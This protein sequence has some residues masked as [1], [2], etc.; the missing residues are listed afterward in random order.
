MEAWAAMGEELAR[1]RS[2]FRFFPV[3]PPLADYID[4]FYTSDVPKHFVDRVLATRLPELEAQLVFA[5]E[6]GK[7]FPGA[8][9]IAEGVSASLFLQPAH[10][11]AIPIPGTIRLAVGA[12]LRPAGMR[13]L[14]RRGAGNLSES[15]LIPL[16]ELCGLGAAV[17]RDRLVATPGTVERLAVLKA[18]LL[19]RAE[20]AGKVHP[21]A[22]HA[23]DLLSAAQGATSVEAVAERCGVTSRTLHK[24][25]LSETALPP[26]QLAR[27]IR[28]RHAL[29]LLNHGGSLTST[30]LR[31]AFADRAHLCREFRALLGTTP[32]TLARE[33]R[34]APHSVP[35]FTTERELLSTGLL[36]RAAP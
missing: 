6:E 4:H 33:M 28:V 13:L 15:P 36:I 19:G 25:L 34:V 11:N 24:V 8:K 31:Q 32:A 20:R 27:V 12:S 30:D 9:W 21:T 7:N 17:L 3:E 26:K 2:L 10:V 23:V 18:Y 29:S 16:D 14:L 22:L 1:R 35:S 5:I